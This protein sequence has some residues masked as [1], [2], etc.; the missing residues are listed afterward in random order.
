MTRSETLTED[1]L[2]AV[3]SELGLGTPTTDRRPR[4]PRQARV[5]ADE[6]SARASGVIVHADL[7]HQRPPLRR[8][9][10]T[11]ARFADAMLGALGHRVRVGGARL[12]QLGAVG[13][14]PAAARDGARGRAD[15]LGARAGASRRSGT[16][17]ARHLARRRRA[18]SCRC[19]TGST[20]GCSTVF[21]LV[22]G[23]EIK[24]EFTVGHLA[25]RRPAALPVA[26]RDRRHGRAGAGL[27]CC[28]I[29]AGPWAHGWGVPMATDTAFAVALI[30]DDGRA[31]AG[32]AAH[33]PDRG[34]DR[35]R[36]R[37]DRRRRALLLRRA[38][39]RLARRRRRRHRR[40]G[41]AQPL[42]ASTA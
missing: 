31:G 4:P 11:R 12:R 32:R 40:P 7:L 10:G 8:R 6:R 18:S 15:Q 3:A 30:V 25:S 29:P 27:R 19:C 38:A 41:A 34:G 28:V 9:R 37:L 36:H 1:D 20:T 16:H 5:A 21:F 39:P 35:R 14:H 13:R 2:R 33:L 26:A 22:V 23:L 17:A 42:A 24:R